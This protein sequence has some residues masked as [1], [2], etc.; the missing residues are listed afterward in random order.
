MKVVGLITEYNPFHYGHKYH[1]E[2]SKKITGANYSIAIMSGSFVQ[3]GE[4]SFI[5]KW[6]KTKIAIDNGIDLILELPV[7]FSTQS[8][9]HF[10]FGGIKL[11]DSLNIVDYIS[12][13]SETEDI[14]QLNKISKILINEP[15]YYNK[16]LVSYLNKGNSYSIARSKA[17]NDYVKKEK[18]SLSESI[19]NI[20]KAPNNILGI[21]YLK[22]LH[23]INSPIKPILVKR[24]GSGYKE[25]KLSNSIPSAT[26]I[27]NEIL[28][29][30]LS[31]IKNKVPTKTYFYLNNYLK[32]YGSF[33]TL[34]N[35]S[36]ILVYLLRTTTSKEISQIVDVEEGLENR[37]VNLSMKYNTLNE[38]IDNIVSKR[39]TRTR[40]QRI[41]IHLLLGIK[42]ENF[43]QLKSQYPKYCRV[44]GAN[45]K[46]LYLLKKIKENSNIPIITKFSE[47]QKINE[48]NFRKMIDYDKKATD[49]F[50]LGLNNE[51]KRWANKDFYISP[52][53]KV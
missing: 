4:P 35:Y 44:L 6:T 17:L 34:E 5:D 53:I 7:I 22:A 3:R 38:I 31:T 48:P 33:N 47:T 15:K 39:H 11:L 27:R 51:K 32:T 52:Y 45:K 37:I 13:G 19:E 49:L 20:M 29:N 2:K 8:A 18:I 12:F 1:L 9:E 42:K 41:F 14:S 25:K 26:A 50:F 10:A 43:T 23:K 21:E 30:N 46:G 36:Q 16:Q 28:N 24:I 40:I